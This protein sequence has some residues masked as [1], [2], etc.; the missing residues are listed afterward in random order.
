MAVSFS[1]LKGD[2]IGKEALRAQFE[3]VNARENGHSLPPK[4]KRLVPKSI[5]PFLYHRAGD[6]Q[7]G[8]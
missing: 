5:V 7:A 1:P 8:S 4:E 3:E 2:F 6:C